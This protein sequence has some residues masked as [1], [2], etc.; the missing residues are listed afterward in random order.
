MEM[1]LSQYAD[2]TQLFLDETEQSLRKSLETLTTFYHMSGLK[3]NT[4]KTKAI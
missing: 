3:I 4:D 2:D 1:I